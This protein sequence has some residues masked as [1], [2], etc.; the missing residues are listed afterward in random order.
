MEKKYDVKMNQMLAGGAIL[1]SD[2]EDFKAR[3]VTKDKGH[4]KMMKGVN[5]LK[6]L[7]HPPCVYT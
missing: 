3:Q 4:Y 5:S 2:R 6:R 1:I 7:N